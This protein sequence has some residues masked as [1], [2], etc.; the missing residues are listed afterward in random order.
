MT[1]RMVAVFM[2]GSVVAVASTPVWGLGVIVALLGAP[3][4]IE[5]RRAKTA[6]RRLAADLALVLELAAR[7]VRTGA[8][9]NDAVDEA[10]RLRPGNAAVCLRG[11]PL[12]SPGDPVHRQRP[13]KFV[14]QS[15][16]SLEIA[17]LVLTVSAQA[18]NGAA[19]A[20][21]AGASILRARHRAAEEVTTGS[22]QARSSA[23]VL[24][25]L[26]MLMGCAAILADPSS[27]ARMSSEP[28]VVAS[29]MSGGALQ[30]IGLRWSRRI[31]RGVG[32][33]RS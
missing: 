33:D 20:L 10:M 29:I 8:T 1:R 5:G 22:A 24:T 25:A 2:I 31:I 26:P 28:L 7:A 23:L 9:P 27:M 30:V 16:P 17:S 15:D 13:G 32:G 14:R 12:R 21:D 19:R 6:D 3:G 4:L 18:G 11:L